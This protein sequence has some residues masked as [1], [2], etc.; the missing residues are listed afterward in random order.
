MAS[1]PL[2]TAVLAFIESVGNRAPHRV[3]RQNPA[4]Y[5]LKL[6]VCNADDSALR[7]AARAALGV[8]HRRGYIYIG[9]TEFDQLMD[10]YDAA[11]NN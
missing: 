8:I 6:S 4:T 1:L 7:D 5:M 2:D 3:Y 10:A 9:D 11:K